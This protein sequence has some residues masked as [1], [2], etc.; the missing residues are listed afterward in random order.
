[1]VGT[2][3]CVSSVA[4]FFKCFSFVGFVRLLRLFSVGAPGGD[5]RGYDLAGAIVSAGSGSVLAVFED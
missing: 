5:R 2:V 4:A 3:T 1:M